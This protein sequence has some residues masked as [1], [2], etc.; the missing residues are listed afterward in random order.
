M[1]DSEPTNYCVKQLKIIMKH[2]HPEKNRRTLVPN[3]LIYVFLAEANFCQIIL[4][5]LN[6][7]III[8]IRENILAIIAYFSSLALVIHT[9]VVYEHFYTPAFYLYL[10][11]INA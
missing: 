8:H 4:H 5:K 9:H 7:F 10:I 1:T 6:L 2:Q 11:I 3:M